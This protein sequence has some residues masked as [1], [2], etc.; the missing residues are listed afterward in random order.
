MVCSFSDDI[1]LGSVAL[2]KGF[3]R[4]HAESTVSRDALLASTNVPTDEVTMEELAPIG[5]SLKN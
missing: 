2:P 1:I 4:N 3:F 5:V